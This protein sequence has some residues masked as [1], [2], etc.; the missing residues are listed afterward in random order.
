M[1]LRVVGAG[2]GRTGTH[3]LKLALEQLLGGPCYHMVRDVRPARRHPG[4]ARRGQRP[5]ARLAGVPR[6]LRRR[7]RLAGVRVLARARRREPR[8]H[9]AALDAGRAR[10]A[11]WKSANDTIFQVSQREIPG[12][13]STSSAR[14]LAMV[15][16]LFANTFTADWRE[17]PAKRA[18]EEH[19]AAVRAAV[20]PAR[21]VDWQ[22]GDGW[23]P[24]LR[25][26]VAAGA[27]RA[28]PTREHHRRLPRDDRPRLT[29]EALTTGR[30]RGQTGRRSA[31]GVCCVPWPSGL[32]R[33]SD[34][35]SV[36]STPLDT[37]ST[38]T[39]M[40]LASMIATPT[41]SAR[42]EL[43]GD[44]LGIGRTHLGVAVVGRDGAAGGS[45][46]GADRGAGH[47]VEDALHAERLGD[48]GRRGRPEDAGL[49]RFA[50][51]EL[52]RGGDAEPDAR[53]GAAHEPGERARQRAGL[54]VVDRVRA[55]LADGDGLL[56]DRDHV[57]GH[58]LDVAQ[59]VDEAVDQRVAAHEQARADRRA[60]VGA[61]VDGRLREEVSLLVRREL[62]EGRGRAVVARRQPRVTDPR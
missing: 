52:H 3:S 10:D 43:A 28:V 24:H 39:P 7:G 27:R 9:R 53:R 56:A 17:A 12:T 15:D 31:T 45:V 48:R 13:T 25:R 5:D 47:A 37:P 2:L 23:E 32:S 4:V 19:N 35:T 26:A 20:D 8:R 46:D 49:A 6:R 57:A 51:R 61:A 42:R 41:P 40:S 21:L 58:E 30:W 14:R 60:G 18:Y 62:R 33:R 55:A 38:L 50:D 44:A 36:A 22:P 1:A 11:W 29:L 59:R 34:S 16:D 54:H